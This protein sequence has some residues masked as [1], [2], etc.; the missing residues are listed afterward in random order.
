M[1]ASFLTLAKD[2]C[3]ETGL[4]VPNA[5]AGS[6]DAGAQQISA[7]L[8]RVGEDV[9]KQTNWQKCSRRV[10]W[11]SVAG[12]DQGDINALCPENMAYIIPRTF[13]DYTRRVPIHGPVTPQ[14]WQSQLSLTPLGPLHTFRIANNRLEVA[15][16]MSAGRNLVLI[17]KTYNW[18]LSG[19]VARS[20]MLL[21]T[22]TSYFSDDTM[23]AGLRMFWLRT[24]QMPHRLELEEYEDAKAAEASN[25][26]VAAVLS[27][28]SQGGN[29]APGIVIPIG[30]WTITP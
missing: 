5:L 2:F 8:Q 7:L 15:P 23:K 25:A 24:K 11:T 28:D 29:F 12:A 14:Q 18:L 1:P 6:A 3:R 27:M 17:Y 4:P 16:S 30:S 13:W 20:A 26:T 9:W 21:D 19:G 10:S 22:D